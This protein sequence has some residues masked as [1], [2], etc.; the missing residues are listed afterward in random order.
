MSASQTPLP[1]A[2]QNAELYNLLSKERDVNHS[3]GPSA[4]L[5][6]DFHSV[7][8][9]EEQSLLSALPEKGNRRSFESQLSSAAFYGV[10]RQNFYWLILLQMDLF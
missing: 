10:T 3:Y 7:G 6:G 8:I 9:Y 1:T 4:P 2:V 5:K